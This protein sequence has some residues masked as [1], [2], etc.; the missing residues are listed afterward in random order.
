MSLARLIPGFA[1]PAKPD[2]VLLPHQVSHY[3]LVKQILRKFLFYFDTSMPGCGKTLIALKLAKDWNY[4]LFIVCPASVQGVWQLEAD[5]YGIPIHFIVSYESLMSTRGHQPKHPYL[6]RIDQDGQ[7]PIF[8]P[9]KALLDLVG[10]TTLFVFDECSKIKNNTAMF[11]AC[12]SITK[13]VV[14]ST[15]TKARIALISA[16]P[17]DNEK[18]AVNSLRLLGMITMDKLYTKDPQTGEMKF[19]GMSELVT[20]CCHYDRA[21]T[22]ETLREFSTINSDNIKT[23][24]YKLFLNVILG[25]MQAIMDIP[26]DVLKRDCRN[27]YYRVR[28]ADRDRL[29][30]LIDTLSRAAGY[31]E[32]TDSIDDNTAIM[33]QVTE[34][35]RQLEMLKARSL[36]DLLVRRLRKHKDIKVVACMEQTDALATVQ[37]I[38]TDAGFSCLALWGKIKAKDRPKLVKQFQEDPNIRCIVMNTQVGGYGISLHD[39]EGDF[40]REIYIMPSFSIER[41]HQATFR[42]SRVGS[43]SIPRIILFFCD[44]G[45]KEMRILNALFRKS[46]IYIAVSKMTDAKKKVLMPGQYPDYIESDD[47]GTTPTTPITPR[48]PPRIVMVTP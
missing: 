40:K 43:K 5:R 36:G 38:V 34:T 39:T 47:E 46:E 26:E 3:S 6:Q 29:V 4:K 9:T 48:S 18:M 12:N 20:Y 42:V 44:C 15:V 31:N 32:K 33:T 22:E 21:K 1:P 16:T 13:S 37:T 24:C 23:V 27:G 14:F 30:D 28:P 45:K 25:V 7:K 2:L 35:V 19:K 17:I 41:I 11:R 10:D 8:V